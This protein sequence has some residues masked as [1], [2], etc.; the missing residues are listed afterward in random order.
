M[1]KRKRPYGEYVDEETGQVT[2]VQ[3][4]KQAKRAHQKSGKWYK[5][6][7][8]A[9]ILAW[10]REEEQQK[11]ANKALQREQNKK[12]NAVKRAEKLAKEQHLKRDL[13]EAGKITFTQTLAKKDEDQLNLHSWFGGRPKQTKPKSN[14]TQRPCLSD[15][16]RNKTIVKDKARTSTK[17]DERGLSELA[18]VESL[19]QESSEDDDNNSDAGSYLNEET[20]RLSTEDFSNPRICNTDLLQPGPRPDQIQN[21]NLSPREHF[22]VAEDSDA[23]IDVLDDEANQAPQL[24]VPIFKV[25]ALPTQ[26]KRPPLSPMTKSDVNVRT[27][28]T[29]RVSSFEDKL[30][31]ANAYPPSTQQVRDILSRICT[32]DLADDLDDD[33]SG[34][35]ENE[36]PVTVASPGSDSPTK[37]S[38]KSL[39][40]LSHKSVVVSSPATAQNN[41]LKE[42]YES[43]DH[44]NIFAEMNISDDTASKD[45]DD[46]DF[47]DCGLDDAT[48]LSVPTTQLVR[49]AKANTDS[50]PTSVP[51]AVEPPTAFPPPKPAKQP[52]KK[53]D[54]F[55]VDDLEEDDL[56]EALDQWEYSQTHRPSPLPS[57][58]GRPNLRS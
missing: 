22:E 49:A 29:K 37:S 13:F 45:S 51:P 43:S 42:T 23:G 9:E 19:S 11:K 55:A 24:L 35:K 52:I 38:T 58:R 26:N 50:F 17:Y 56:Q 28:Q 18:K 3:T 14:Q 31:K 8:E 34:D 15:E 10:D 27:S 7:T 39:H 36:Q 48:L 46:E 6:P 12:T 5:E 4:T 20:N 32:Q 54:S 41:T 2:V 47:D 44:D 33:V 1:R 40:K 21:T 16:N 53:S 57:R 30:A 25:P